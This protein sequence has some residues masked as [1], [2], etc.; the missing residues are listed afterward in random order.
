MLPDDTRHDPLREALSGLVQEGT[1]SGE[2]AQRVDTVLRAA[3]IGPNT[4]TASGA[5]AASGGAAADERR[6][7]MVEVFS[8]LGGA[9]VIGALILIVGLAWDDLGRAGKL[10]ICGGT[11]LLLLAAA[12]AIGRRGAGDD[13]ARRRR[14]HASTLA[15]VASAGVAFT[16]GVAF[17]SDA[18]SELLAPGISML[19][20]AAGGYLVWRGAPLLCGIFGG[21]LLIVIALLEMRPDAWP[22]LLVVG[23]SL[24]AYGIAW[25]GIGRFVESRHVAGVLGG[26]TGIVGAEL[27]SSSDEYVGIGLVLGLVMIGLMF[28]LF[29]TSRQWSYAA[30]GAVGALVVPPTALGVLFDNALLA[31]VVLLVIGVVLIAGAVTVVRRRAR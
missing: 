27:V 12:A 5:P 22:T 19:V 20:V 14:T 21:G 30:L 15:A 31:G 6:E 10:A 13:T 7:R 16:A 18:F 9:L 2:Q 23:A 25:I 1:L 24:V 17:D 11:S 3:H 28:V 29:W 26:V 8:Y 4:H